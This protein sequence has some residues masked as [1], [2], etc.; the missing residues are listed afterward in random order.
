MRYEYYRICF[1]IDVLI[2][3]LGPIIYDINTIGIVSVYACSVWRFGVKLSN[4]SLVVHET[5]LTPQVKR[6]STIAR[7]YTSSGLRLQTRFTAEL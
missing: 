7:S 3:C 4:R 2:S 1:G 5:K 6:W